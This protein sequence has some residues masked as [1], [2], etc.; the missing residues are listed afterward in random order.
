MCIRDSTYIEKDALINDTIDMMRHAATRALLSR[1]DVIIVASSFSKL[2]SGSSGAS[3]GVN[4]R[5]M[6]ARPSSSGLRR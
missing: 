3:G 4:V 2:T 1:K 5:Q 6:R